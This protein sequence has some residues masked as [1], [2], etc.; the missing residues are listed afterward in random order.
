[1]PQLRVGLR[2]MSDGSAA[3]FDEIEIVIIDVDA[4]R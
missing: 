1:M 2:T 4:V 3:L